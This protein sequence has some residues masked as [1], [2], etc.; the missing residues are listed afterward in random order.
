MRSTG[1]KV[2]I[3]AIIGDMVDIYRGHFGPLIGVSAAIFIVVGLL[4]A[5]L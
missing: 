3:G 4:Q 2:E 1:G 5:G